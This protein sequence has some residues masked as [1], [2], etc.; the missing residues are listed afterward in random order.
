MNDARKDNPLEDFRTS[1][2]VTHLSVHDEA[3]ISWKGVGIPGV[4]L[5]GITTIVV[6]TKT[7]TLLKG[8]VLT[9]E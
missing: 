1:A 4:V 9:Y 8:R 6:N 5:E 3:S 2:Y 7:T